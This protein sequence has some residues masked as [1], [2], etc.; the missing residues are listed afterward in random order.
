MTKDYY[1]ILGVP[2]SASDKEIKSA[3]RKLAMKYHPDK[4]KDTDTTQKFQEISQA[5]ETLSNKQKRSMYDQY[6][7][8]AANNMGQGGHQS[9]GGFGDFSDIF[10][11]IFGGGKG[12]IFGDMFSQGRSNRPSRGNDLIFELD[13]SLEDAVYGCKKTIQIPIVSECDVCHGR[14]RQTWIKSLVHSPTCHGSGKL[15]IQQGFLNIQQA[16]P[17]YVMVRAL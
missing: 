4:N 6:G 11:D 14:W 10:N 3:Y 9:A 2:K 16:C 13:I 17:T 15:N 5:Y 12:D 7:A 1:E 8:D